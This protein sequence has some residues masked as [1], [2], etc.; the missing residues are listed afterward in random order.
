M[1]VK[2]ISYRDLEESWRV[3][4]CTL[5]KK[6]NKKKN[7]FN[8]ILKGCKCIKSTII[9]ICK[10]KGGI[11]SCTNYRGIKPIS[12]TIKLWEKVIEYKLRMTT[13][14]SENQIDLMLGIFTMEAIS[15]IRIMELQKKIRKIFTCCLLTRRRLMI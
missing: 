11:Q 10:N 9:S 5:N 14:V 15:L 8:V 6:N 3:K 13:R 12:H 7:L 2:Y 1:L 4:S